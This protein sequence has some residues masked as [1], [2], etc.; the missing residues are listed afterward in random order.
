MSFSWTNPGVLA[1]VYPAEMDAWRIASTIPFTTFSHVSEEV[2]ECVISSE[3]SV[4]SAWRSL[5]RSGG[6]ALKVAK[7]SRCEVNEAMEDIDSALDI[8]EEVLVS[9]FGGRK[10]SVNTRHNC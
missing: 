3:S 9:L 7:A 6:R 5:W 8:T 10:G 2:P 4:P 1:F